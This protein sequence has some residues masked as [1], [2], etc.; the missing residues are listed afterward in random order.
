LHAIALLKGQ[1]IKE[2][3]ALAAERLMLEELHKN[4]RSEE[5]FRKRHMRK[6]RHRFLNMDL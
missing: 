2:E 1:I 3:R 5:T 4:A 6:V